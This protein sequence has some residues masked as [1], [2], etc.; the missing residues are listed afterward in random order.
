MF[1]WPALYIVCESRI[2]HRMVIVSDD[3][4]IVEF[5]RHGLENATQN[6]K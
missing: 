3:I 1:P 6:T 2:Q 5:V 4:D